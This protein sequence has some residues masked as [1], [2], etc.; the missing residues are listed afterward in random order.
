MWAALTRADPV[1]DIDFIRGGWNSPADPRVEPAER[2]K[3]K[4]TNSRMIINACRPYHWRDQFV[5][6]VKPSPEL[7]RRAR[8]KFGWLLD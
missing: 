5:A 1:S 6:A 8:E 3:G 4:V 2:A 7:S